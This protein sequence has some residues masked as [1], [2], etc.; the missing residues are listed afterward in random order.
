[1][2]FHINHFRVWSQEVL[3]SCLKSAFE[4]IGP[5]TKQNCTPTLV[6]LSLLT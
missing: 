4:G 5:K 2:R 1:M 3:Y 6:W